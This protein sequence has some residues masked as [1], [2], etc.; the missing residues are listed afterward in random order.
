MESILKYK[1]ALSLLPG[2]G[3][4]R[5]RKIIARL[6]DT[7]SFFHEPAEHLLK[8]QGIGRHLASSAIRM[9]A[10]KAAEDEL[11]FLTRNHIRA[12]FF[13]DDDYPERLKQCED[14]PIIIYLQGDTDL[15]AKKVLSIVGTR[16][17]TSYGLDHCRKI[18]EDLARSHPDLLIVS[19][20]AYGIDVCAHKAALKNQLQT[21]AVLGHGLNMIYPAV[22]RTVAL[23]IVHHGALVTEF[24]TKQIPDKRNFVARNRII[25]GLADATIIIESGIK[26]GALIT[27]DL[28]NSYNR[29]V[30]AIPGRISDTWSKGCNHLIKK[31]LAALVEDAGDIAYLLGWET[32]SPSHEDIQKELF[33]DLNEE[34]LH[35]VNILKELG[36][37]SMDQ[38]AIHA[39][40][41][42]SKTSS[43][44]L[45]LEFTGL[46]KSLPGNMYHFIS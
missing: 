43:L 35:L 23:D 14:A 32:E 36:D 25:A 20:L 34:E 38:I 27:A 10:L 42:V 8:I 19:G 40:M 31:N 3:P 1:I 13:L 33:V 28:A 46:I 17:A 18:I 37:L 9:K 39:N 12:F 16:Q 26:G 45:N 15:N 41:P 24:N 44:L 7:E 11:D 5:T 22:H 30:F 2:I 4:L 29:D 21:V 6:K